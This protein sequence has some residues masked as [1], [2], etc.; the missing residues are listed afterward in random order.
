MSNVLRV[1]D[2]VVE[3]KAAEGLIRAVDGVSF[4]V[5]EGKTVALVG[6][7]GSGKSVVSQT[8]MQILPTTGNIVGGEVLFDSLSRPTKKQK[9][10]SSRL[11]TTFSALFGDDIFESNS[12]NL[13]V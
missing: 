4:T 3:F 1:R 6:E 11:P 10:E 12:N 7:S 9:M 2:L 13:F 8:I 5:P